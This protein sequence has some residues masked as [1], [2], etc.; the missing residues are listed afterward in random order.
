MNM[1]PAFISGVPETLPDACTVF[2]SFHLVQSLNKALDEV[3]IKERR[4]KIY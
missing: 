3:R 4:G 2:D 1:S